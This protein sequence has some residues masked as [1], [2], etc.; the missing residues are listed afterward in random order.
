MEEDKLLLNTLR[1]SKD[2]SNDNAANFKINGKDFN[3]MYFY[4]II[5]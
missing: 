1:I 2:I 5:V 3:K 4:D